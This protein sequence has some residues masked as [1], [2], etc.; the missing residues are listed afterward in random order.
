MCALP[1][2]GHSCLSVGVSQ[3]LVS[4]TCARWGQDEGARPKGGALMRGHGQNGV[5]TTPNQMRRGIQER[6]LVRRPPPDLLSA[7][8]RPD[9]AL[10]RPLSLLSRTIHKGQ[11]REVADLARRK[12]S[13]GGGLHVACFPRCRRPPMETSAALCCACPPLARPR[14]YHGADTGDRSVLQ[15]QIRSICNV[16]YCHATRRA[17]SGF[18]VINKLTDVRGVFLFDDRALIPTRAL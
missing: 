6:H 3:R 5:M 15:K 17:S 11:P 16:C 9:C 4:D 7:S 14:L 13:S 8:S 12:G 18:Q 10:S 1:I 2:F